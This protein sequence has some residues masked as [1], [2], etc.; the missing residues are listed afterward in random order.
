MDNEL[1][2]VRVTLSDAGRVE[3]TRLSFWFKNK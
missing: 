3:I 1:R 2:L